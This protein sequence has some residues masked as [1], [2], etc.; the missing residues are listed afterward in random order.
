M[1]ENGYTFPV[2]LA[3]QLVR[4]LLDNIVI[5]QNWLVDSKGKWKATQLGFDATDVDWVNNMVSKLESAR[6]NQ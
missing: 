5:P 3:H 4:G 2:L 1:K 6:S